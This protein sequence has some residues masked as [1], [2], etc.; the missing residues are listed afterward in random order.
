MAMI[1]ST[2][3]YHIIH[4]TYCLARRWSSQLWPCKDESRHPCSK[5]R[6]TIIVQAQSRV[7][8]IKVPVTD[9]HDGSYTG[10]FVPAQTGKLS[11]SVILN[12]C[13]SSCY[14]YQVCPYTESS[15]IVDGWM[16]H[17]VL[18]VVKMV[19]GQ[20]HK[21]LFKSAIV[22][23]IQS[24]HIVKADWLPNLSPMVMDL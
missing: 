5:G 12:G 6:S 4:W 20:P 16:G 3:S 10:S 24:A 9:N 18:H 14:T 21:S 19:F 23:I 8:V 2:V 15:K 17:G 7:E 11:L 1:L 22:V 13:F